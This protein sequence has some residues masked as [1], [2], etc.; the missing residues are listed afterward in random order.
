MKPAQLTPDESQRPPASMRSAG[1]A[2]LGG[3]ILTL[4][5]GVMSVVIL[6]LVLSTDA[7]G[8]FFL[9][10]IFIAGMAI[11]V[12]FGLTFTIPATVTASIANNDLGR[13]RSMLLLIGGFV[14]A[15]GIAV[16]IVVGAGA[17]ALRGPLNFDSPYLT[18]TVLVLVAF[19]IPLA[20]LSAVLVEAL[21][22]IHAP[23]SAAALGA[24]PGT[25]LV[26]GLL[27]MLALGMQST[28]GT[29]LLLAASG[30]LLAI[31]LG[32]W[33]L[34]RKARGWPRAARERPSLS[35]VVRHAV[36]NLAATVALYGLSQ[37]EMFLA[38]SFGSLTEVANY[39][40][41]LRISALLLMPLSIAN[42]A[43]SPL[44]V[45]HWTS[46]NRA[47]LEA[48]LVRIVAVCSALTI[49]MYLGLIILGEIFVQIWNPEYRQ[50]Y[51]LSLIIGAGQV[52][53]VLGGSSGVLLM[54]LGDQKA[55]FRII[56]IWGIVTL[57]ACALATYFAGP[58]GLAIAA[59]LCNGIQVM[60]FAR[61]L[62]KRFGV[63]ASILSI[64][65]QRR[66]LRA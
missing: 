16:A 37:L 12:Q 15:L 62:S 46:G 5:T 44:M 10:Q 47:E 51:Y 36:P 65:T 8:T 20:G 24:L 34:V 6:P 1:L 64:A 26:V 55:A 7:V 61:R 28:I 45:H 48:M 54:L 17:L 35:L 23:K 38:A 3:R 49:A 50:S 4:L 39:G 41:A 2:V 66:V 19:T 63:A 21:R 29:V 53:H 18:N 43:F 30:H 40:V 56:L 58:V 31:L 27:A 11:I 9:I 14:S 13:A 32:A 57:A 25:T 42:S 33:F 59:A 52:V 60:L 22:A